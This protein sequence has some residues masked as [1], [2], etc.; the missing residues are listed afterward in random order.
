MRVAG[1]R[2]VEAAARTQHRAYAQ[3]I[4]A[5]DPHE[6]LA[7]R[8]HFCVIDFQCSSRLRRKSFELADRAA[9]RADT[10]TSTGGKECWFKRKD[11]RASRLM[12]LRP[13]P[14]PTL[15]APIAKPN[16]PFFS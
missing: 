10:E 16:Q 7:R 3:L 8:Y 13:T 4:S 12:P 11:S 2:R 9:S 15:P 5:D 1:A 6:K 14:V